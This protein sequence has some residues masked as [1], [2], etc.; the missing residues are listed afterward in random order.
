MAD[1]RE[2]FT[3]TRALHH[4]GDTV[5]EP[6][7]RG[8][9]AN[10]PGFKQLKLIRGNKSTTCFVEFADVPTAMACHAAQQVRTSLR[11]DSSGRRSIG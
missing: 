3:V 1:Q 11:L 4:A 10:S 2:L 6:E 5:S 9:F 8:L 7:L